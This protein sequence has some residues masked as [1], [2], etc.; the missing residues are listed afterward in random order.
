MRG[1]EGG[2]PKGWAGAEHRLWACRGSDDLLGRKPCS[3][4]LVSAFSQRLRCIDTPHHRAGKH[5]AVAA[6]ALHIVPAV[7][8]LPENVTSQRHTEAQENRC[9]LP[10][11]LRWEQAQDATHGDRRMNS[12]RWAQRENTHEP[13]SEAARREKMW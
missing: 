3:W 11:G 9:S 10:G 4:W 2:V 7:M 12:R 1:S 5:S 13:R 6:G 8:T